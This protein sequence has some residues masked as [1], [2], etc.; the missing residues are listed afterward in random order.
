MEH[1]EPGRARVMIAGANF[2]TVTDQCWSRARRLRDIDD[3]GVDRQVLSPMPELLSYWFSPE[4]GLEMARHVNGY[5]A[6]LVQAEPTRFYGLGM[7]PLQDVDLAAK[8]LSEVRD[9]GLRGVEVGSNVLGHSLGEE[10]FLGFW[11]EVERLDLSVFVHALHPTFTDRLVGPAQVTNAVGFPADTGLTAASL[12]SGGTAERFPRL[13]VAFSHGGGTFPFLLPR[14]ENAWS[15][16]WNEE[17]PPGGLPV[18]ASELRQALPR[19]PAEYAR[20]FYYDSLLFDA[21]AVG[22]LVD[23]VG[24]S[25]VVVGTDYPFF[26]RERPVDRTLQMLDLPAG[27]LEDIRSRNALRFLGVEGQ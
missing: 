19:S 6:A 12:I 13:R 18:P 9:F 1:F 14:F 11:E 21:R 2:R 22:Y 23:M 25:Q 17:R 24:A 20:R 5:I 16:T 3:E 7:A 10:C 4:D 27:Q 15:G 26:P 8:T